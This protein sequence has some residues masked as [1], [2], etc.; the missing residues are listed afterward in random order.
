MFA[1]CMMILALFAVEAEKHAYA[2]PELLMEPAHLMKPETAKKF[3]IL[4]ARGKA[5]YQAGHVP[6][7]VHVEA[8]R[9]ASAFG[10][11]ADRTG[12][13]KRIGSLGIDTD[14]PVVVYDASRNKDAA[15]IWW[16]LRYWGVKDVRLLNG[17]W[18]GWQAAG[19][20]IETTENA[21]R[22]RKAELTAGSQHIATRSHLIPLLKAGKAGQIVDARSE[23]EYCGEA[24]TAKRNGAIP[25]AKH[26]EWSATL[27]AKTGRFKSHAELAKLL[28]DAGIDPKKPTTTY[29][30]SGG[31][32]SVMA[33]VL[34]LMGGKPARN[35]YRSWAE[36][37][38]A[39]DTPI[40]KSKK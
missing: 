29:C 38:N 21:P 14:S 30:Q 22:P 6:G 28:E 16:I 10:D 39:S 8:G 17:G 23:M 31:R 11:G 20:K 37:G 26:L 35:Y 13:S 2:R 9:W 7:A 12:W 25:G 33:F 36:W 27:D 40:V 19:D 4:D 32:A 3:V 18:D 1:G 5:S 15:R 24:L 34:E